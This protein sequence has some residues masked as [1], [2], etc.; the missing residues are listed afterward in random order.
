MSDS[1]NQNRSKYGGRFLSIEDAL[2]TPKK[3]ER[4]RRPDEEALSERAEEAVTHTMYHVVDAGDSSKVTLRQ[5]DPFA[6]ADA[7][8]EFRQWSYDY[9]ELT[10]SRC[11]MAMPSGPAWSLASAW[12]MQRSLGRQGGWA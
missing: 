6:A 10:D 9:L 2:A 5:M 12:K 1:A 3:R 7:Y 4:R 11:P 8:Q